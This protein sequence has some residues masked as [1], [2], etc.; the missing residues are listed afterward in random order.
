MVAFRG[1][2]SR[3]VSRITIERF[4]LSSTPE[5]TVDPSLVPAFSTEQQSGR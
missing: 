2:G 4:R 5:A 1:S 3:V